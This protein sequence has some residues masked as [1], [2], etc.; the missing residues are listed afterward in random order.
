MKLARVD[1]GL[2]N[3]YLR[4]C[5][6][7]SAKIARVAAAREQAEICRTRLEKLWTY[8]VLLTGCPPPV[9]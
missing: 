4:I 3:F 5:K 9:K 1:P 2:A 8:T 6:R 7:A